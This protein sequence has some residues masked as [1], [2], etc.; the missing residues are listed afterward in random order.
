MPRF[1]SKF[2]TIF[3]KVAISWWFFFKLSR[4]TIKRPIIIFVFSIVIKE[5]K[6]VLLRNGV[7]M[8]MKSFRKNWDSHFYTLVKVQCLWPV[9]FSHHVRCFALTLCWTVWIFAHDCKRTHISSRMT[10]PLNT[11]ATKIKKAYFFISPTK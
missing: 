10:C 3:S 9:I 4:F 11:L 2:E 7:Q 1:T 8:S 6:R 5:G